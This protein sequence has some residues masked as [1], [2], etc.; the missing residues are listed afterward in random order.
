LLT[1]TGRKSG[2][3]RTTPLGFF[4]QD[5][6]YVIIASNSGNDTHPAWF[7]NLN[8]DLHAS[9]EVRG[10]TIEV[11]AEI[12]EGEKRRELWAKLIEHSPDYAV[13]EKRTSREIPVVILHPVAI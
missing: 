5:G 7:F 12:S 1:T 8:N 10:K 6:A 4:I 13:Y 11:I 9:I 2:K 3:E